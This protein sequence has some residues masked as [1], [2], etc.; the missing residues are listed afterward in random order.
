MFSCIRH[1]E[2]RL[3]MSRHCCGSAKTDGSGQARNRKETRSSSQGDGRTCASTAVFACFR[4]MARARRR[5]IVEHGRR[6]G[7]ARILLSAAQ[8]STAMNPQDE[9]VLHLMSTPVVALSPKTDVGE[10]LRLS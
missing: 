3:H 4:N 7:A 8:E 5:G 1:A 2:R 9:A 10:M 6:A